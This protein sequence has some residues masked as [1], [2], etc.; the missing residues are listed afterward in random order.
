M[1]TSLVAVVEQC[2]VGRKA[3][4]GLDLMNRE[5]CTRVCHH[6][7]YTTLVHGDDIRVSLHHIHMVLLGNLALSLIKTIEFALL[8][9]YVRLRRIDIFLLHALGARVEQ[10]SAESVHLACH[11]EPREYHSSGISINKLTIVPAIAKSGLHK[12]IL[13]I[14]RSHCRPGEGVALGEGISQ[15]EFLDDVIAYATTAEILQ[16]DGLSVGV[17]LE[18]ILKVAPR[19]LIHDIHTLAVVGLLLLLCRQFA[20]LYLDIVFLG[21]PSQ[22]VGICYLLVLHKEIDGIAALAAGKAVA[23]TLCGRHHERGSLVVV[24]RTEALVVDASLAQGDKFRDDIHNVCRLH[25][26]VYSISIYHNRCKVSKKYMKIVTL[27]HFYF[28]K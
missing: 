15:F 6:I 9:E 3:S 17:L 28:V 20:L 23:Y 2:D 12:I 25:Y 18:D 7:T 5:S 19:P 26:L 24:E 22:G 16:S 8:M 21:K 1:N 27:F 11:R 14:S 4:Q 13:L 10:S